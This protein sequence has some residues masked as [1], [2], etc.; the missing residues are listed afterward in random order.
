[1]L[2]IK[3]P[4]TTEARLRERAALEGKELDALV[5]EALEE[6]LADPPASA[7]RELPLDE[8]SAQL[9][10]WAKSHPPLDHV[11]DDSRENIY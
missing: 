11:A 1:M 5:L 10:A 2:E 8:W 7:Y 4:K 6:K 9:T 3:L